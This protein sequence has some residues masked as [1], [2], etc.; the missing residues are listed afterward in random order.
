MM[1]DWW[2]LDDYSITKKLYEGATSKVYMAVC[3]HS[4][5]TVALKIYNKSRLHPINHVQVKREVDLH[6]SLSHPNIIDLYGAFEDDKH[7]YL[8]QEFAYGGDLFDEMRRR[9][10]LM[11]EKE[12]VTLVVQP[13]FDALLYCHSKGIVHRDIKPENVLFTKDMTLK[14]ADFGLAVDQNEERPVTRA[15]TL[16]YMAPEVLKNPGKKTP[17]CNK[18]RDDLRYDDK[19]CRDTVND[20]SLCPSHVDTWSSA[21]M[22]YELLY[23][24]PTFG[25]NDHDTTATKIFAMEPRFYPD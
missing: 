13:L 2:C 18:D 12:V 8:V 4:N 7:Y 22:V 25:K 1:R 24:F 17:E 3:K 16:E 10:G 11:S 23:G 5:I 19:V 9:R 20:V 14:V 21:V 15:G 6:C